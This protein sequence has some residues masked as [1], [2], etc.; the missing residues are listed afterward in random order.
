[1]G[2]G[3][4]VDDKNSIIVIEWAEKLG[5]QLPKERIDIYFETIDD[6]KRKITWK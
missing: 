3:E 1:L 5:S 2:L 6:D 4:I